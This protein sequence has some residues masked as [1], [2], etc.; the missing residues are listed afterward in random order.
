M[1]FS[2]DTIIPLNASIKKFQHASHIFITLDNQKNALLIGV[3]GRLPYLSRRKIF[4]R[5]REQGYDH[6]TPVSE[7]PTPQGL[8]SVSASSII[9]I[10]RVE[11]KRVGAARLGFAQE[12][13]GT[14]SLLSGGSMAMHISDVSYWTL[15]AIGRWR[16]IGFMVYIQQ[17]I[18]SFS[19]GILVRMS[20][21]PWFR[22]L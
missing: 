5:L 19:M 14:H 17:H 4:L 15:M 2:R 11:F 7:Y 9:T 8:C 12:D 21:Q 22:H 1:L 18:S 20:A 16:F 13:I 10:I 3:P 6:S